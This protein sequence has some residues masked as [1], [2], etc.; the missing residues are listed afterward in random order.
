MATRIQ[1]V[2]T[3]TSY[4]NIG[5]PREDVSSSYT[6]K[7]LAFHNH[8]HSRC[9]HIVYTPAFTQHVYT[10]ALHTIC[11]HVTVTPTESLRAFFLC[12]RS[13]HSRC[14]SSTKRRRA[15]AK[16]SHSCKRHTSEQHCDNVPTVAIMG[17]HSSGCGCLLTINHNSS[18][19]QATSELSMEGGWDGGEVTR[20]REGLR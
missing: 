7:T 19:P 4:K 17:K 6:L 11:T 14:V 5:I 16:G 20:G 9:L 15:P 13:L 3:W 10:S 8:V 1:S 12:T 18:L 2:Y